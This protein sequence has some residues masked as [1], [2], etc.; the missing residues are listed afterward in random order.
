MEEVNYESV[1]IAI[2]DDEG[3]ILDSYRRNLQKRG[4]NVKTYINPVEALKDLKVNDVDLILLDY[5]MPEKTGGEFAE[6]YTGKAVI[7][8]QTGHAGELPSEETLDRLNIQGYFDKSKG[9]EELIV[10]VKSAIKTSKLIRKMDEVDYQERFFG[11]LLLNITAEMKEQVAIMTE[12]KQALKD[13]ENALKSEELQ[14]IVNI[15]QASVDKMSYLIRVL[16]FKG[17]KTETVNSIF[18]T[19]N[20]LTLPTSACIF[21]QTNEDVYP[22][23]KPKYLVYILAEIVMYLYENGVT[24]TEFIATKSVNGVNI[25]VNKLYEYND[26]IIRKINNIISFDENINMSITDNLLEIIINE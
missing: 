9:F 24:G 6:E 13:K 4:F 5:Y 2:V 12:S 7:I 20:I 19:A 25:L 8:L 15:W 26:D 22:N 1:K 16:N 23:C 17:A 14:K 11:K 10:T 18:D 3:F 21:Q